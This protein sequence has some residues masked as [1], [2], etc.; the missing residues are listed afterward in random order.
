MKTEMTLFEAIETRRSV[1]RW[2]DKIRQIL[3]VPTDVN[4]SAILPIGRPAE[5]PPR[6]QKATIDQTVHYDRFGRKHL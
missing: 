6:P 3:D 5:N 2:H 1:R 4:V